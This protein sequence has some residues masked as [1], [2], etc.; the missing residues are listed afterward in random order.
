MQTFSPLGR[1]VDDASLGGM[2]ALA[3]LPLYAP[4]V[5]RIRRK[6]IEVK[7]S[8]AAGANGSIEDGIAD[9]PTE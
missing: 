5:G 1:S 9:Q 2:K 8:A 7:S 6:R 3:M 4:D